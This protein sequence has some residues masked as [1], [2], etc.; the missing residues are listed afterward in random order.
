[1]AWLPKHVMFWPKVLN[2]GEGGG[3]LNFPKVLAYLNLSIYLAL[4]RLRASLPRNRNI[5]GSLRKSAPGTRIRI[6]MWL[7]RRQS[8][9]AEIATEAARL[10]SLGEPDFDPFSQ[11]LTPFLRF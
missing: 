3:V 11:I 10:R 4:R 8:G 6:I 9:E 5:K 1:M 7:F 2:K